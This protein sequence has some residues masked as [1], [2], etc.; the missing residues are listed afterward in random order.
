MRERHRFSP[1]F[2]TNSRTPTSEMPEVFIR[3]PVCPPI[4]TTLG[5]SASR[6]AASTRKRERSV[7]ILNPIGA[8]STSSPRAEKFVARGWAVWVDDSTIRFVERAQAS[9][10]QKARAEF[11]EGAVETCAAISVRRRELER[12]ERERSA[13]GSHT[14]SEWECILAASG[15]R[16]LRCGARGVK[17]TKDHVIPLAEGGS[18]SASNLQPLCARC[19]SSKGA[20]IIRFARELAV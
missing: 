9:T 3:H 8:G 17:L 7:L 2:A 4:H 18:N 1:P 20:R 10:P 12:A 5:Q 14:Q 16:C 11:R 13:P 6:D 15:R 19:N